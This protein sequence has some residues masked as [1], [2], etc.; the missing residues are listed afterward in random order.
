MA[1]MI[2][3]LKWR[4]D[5]SF[6]AAAFNDVDNL[7][8]A[9]IVYLE[10]DKIVPKPGSP[11]EITLEAAV[12][13]YFKTHDEAWQKKAGHME[14]AAIITAKEMVKTRRFK[15]ISLFAYMNEIS[16]DE[17]SQFCVMQIRTGDGCLY[18]SF[19]GTD[20]TIVGWK[21]NFNMSFLEQT[22]G[23][24]KA[25]QYMNTYISGDESTIRVGGHSKGGNLSVYASVYCEPHIQE[26]I[27]RVYNNDGPGFNKIVL[28][29]EKYHRMLP[30]ILTILPESSI[31]G[32]LMQHEET[33]E[34]VA[35]SEKPIYQHDPL[36]WLVM[37]S[38]FVRVETLAK[39]SLLL[40]TKL[41]SWISGMLP[42]EREEFVEVIFDILDEA[43]IT[44]AEEL[45]QMN[46]KTV[47]DLVRTGSRFDKENQKILSKT[48]RKLW[49]EINS[50]KKQGSDSKH[51]KIT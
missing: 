31:V 4:G 51:T 47:I 11:M 42:E 45:K 50:P 38:S 21:E 5:L 24:K 35:S 19:S 25:V 46:L 7:L 26:K 23:Q 33:Y 44:T 15:D 32:M 37:G 39:G 13:E 3:Y 40:D 2:E 49:S 27:L 9:Q 18:V 16:T 41:K 1:N 20:N 22:P 12:E 30:K 43:H 14:Q 17:E 36:S 6:D 48:L 8:L 28:E 10:L 34:V 29:D